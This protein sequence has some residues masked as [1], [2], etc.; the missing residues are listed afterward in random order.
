MGTNA[1]CSCLR[2]NNMM[3]VLLTV[4]GWALT[5]SQTSQGD[6]GMLAVRAALLEYVCCIYPRP[7]CTAKN[8]ETVMNRSGWTAELVLDVKRKFTS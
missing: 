7:A 8:M 3:S 5:S 1:V 6:G 2:P 4:A